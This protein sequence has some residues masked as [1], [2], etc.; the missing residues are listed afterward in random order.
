MSWADPLL[1]EQEYLTKTLAEYG[2]KR[3]DVY[4]TNIVKH[5]SPQNRKPF[6]DE[7]EHTYLS[8]HSN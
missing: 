1:A 8:S 7:L 6:D 5:V 3:E 4:I 2:I